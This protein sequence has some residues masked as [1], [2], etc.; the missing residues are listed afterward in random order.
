MINPTIV[1]L[2]GATLRKLVVDQLGYPLEKHTYRTQDGYINT[3]YRIPGPRG[4]APGEG[5]RPGAGDGAPKPV[6][7]YQHGLCDSCVG[8]LCDEEDSLG[9][10]LVNEGYDLWMN[11]SRGN[12][13]SRDHSYLDPDERGADVPAEFWKFSFHE[14]AIYDQPAAWEYI[15][16]YTKAKKITYIGHSQGTT[17]MFAALSENPEFFK[18]RMHCFIAIAPAARCG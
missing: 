11:N 3:L 5:D 17:Q 6:V 15:Q 8:C 2:R 1:T 10:R 7:L 18:E 13:Y 14:L 9:L 16:N 4:T 12:R